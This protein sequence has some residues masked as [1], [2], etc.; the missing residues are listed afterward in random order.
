[1]VMGDDA[2]IEA[3]KLY[4][5]EARISSINRRV[6]IRASTTRNVDK[7]KPLDETDILACGR[8]DYPDLDTHVFYFLIKEGQRCPSVKSSWKF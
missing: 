5:K 1:M 6:S 2:G 3:G 4:K 8:Q 7:H